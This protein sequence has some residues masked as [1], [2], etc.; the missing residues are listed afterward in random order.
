MNSQ[1]RELLRDLVREYLRNLPADVAEARRREILDAQPEGIR[2]AWAGADKEGSPHYYRIQ[3]PTFVIE[4]V[5]SQPD[6]AGNP[7]NHIHSVWRDMR[8]DFAIP[9]LGC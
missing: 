2:F 8:G 6:A 5:N 1:Q 9:A 4:F 7:A 3:G